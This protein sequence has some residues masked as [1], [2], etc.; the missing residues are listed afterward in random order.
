MTLNFQRMLCPV[1]SQS[2][3]P[4]SP[5]NTQHIAHTIP[6][7]RGAMKKQGRFLI[8]L[9]FKHTLCP[10]HSQPAAAEWAGTNDNPRGSGSSRF[11]KRMFY[12]SYPLRS[13]TQKKKGRFLIT[14]NFQRML[15]P[16]H[17]QSCYPWSPENTQHIAHTIPCDRGAMKKQGR[18]LI[19]LNF[20]HTLCPEHSQPAAAE[21]AGTNDNP[22]GS[23]SSRFHKLLDYL[24][25]PLIHPQCFCYCLH[26]NKIFPF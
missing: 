8:T 19:T 1:H 23:G 17:S 21:W 9:N 7:D 10:E 15:C 14:L 18:F 6:C 20:K 12:S 26:T 22:R 25:S 5:E 3:Y 24:E 16:V 4:W 2:C 11:H 13:S